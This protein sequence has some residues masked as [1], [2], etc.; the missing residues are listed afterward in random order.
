M[1]LA[2]QKHWLVVEVAK[3]V[4]SSYWRHEWRKML[5]LVRACVNRLHQSR[6][7]EV[8]YSWFQ[9]GS[10]NLSGSAHIKSNMASTH[11]RRQQGQPQARSSWVTVVTR[12]VAWRAKFVGVGC[13][14]G[15]CVRPAWEIRGWFVIEIMS[16]RARIWVWVWFWSRHFQSESVFWLA[17]REAQHESRMVNWGSSEH[18]ASIVQGRHWLCFSDPSQVSLTNERER[19][20]TLVIKS[21]RLDAFKLKASDNRQSAGTRNGIDNVN[22][23][24]IHVLWPRFTI[25]VSSRRA[26]AALVARK[27]RKNRESRIKRRKNLRTPDSR[28]ELPISGYSIMWSHWWSAYVYI[29]SNREVADFLLK[30]VFTY[31]LV[32]ELYCIIAYFVTFDRMILYGATDDMIEIYTRAMGFRSRS[33]RRRNIQVRNMTDHSSITKIHDR[34]QARASPDCPI[35]SPNDETTYSRIPAMS[36]TRNDEWNSSQLQ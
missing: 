36:I 30:I 17:K 12:L 9:K 32:W 35:C 2:L 26:W 28:V 13:V 16:V 21:S 24:S 14:S 10:M 15:L 5:T 6:V 7:F 23:E 33:R 25:R 29:W 34:I 8:V 27:N 18:Q 4:G 1:L 19:C 22:R 20:T 11:S 31:L 3:G